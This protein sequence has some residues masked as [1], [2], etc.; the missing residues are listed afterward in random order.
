MKTTNVTEKAFVGNPH[1]RLDEGEVASAM[2]RRGSLLYVMRLVAFGVSVAAAWTA[3]ACQGTVLSVVQDVDGYNSWPMIQVV[4]G[5]LVCAY[6]RGKGHYVEGS[7]G[8]YA[9]TSSDGGRTWSPEVC[10]MNDPVICEGA[11]GAGRDSSGAAL[12]WMN[13]RGRG[14]IRHELYRTEDG[15]TFTKI[16]APE[17]SPEPIQVTGIFTVPDVGLMSL[18]FTGDYR[19]GEPCNSWGTLVSRDD[20]KT[21]EQRTMESGLAKQDWPTEICAVPLGGGRLLAIGRSEGNVQRQ[22]QLT[23]LDGG[24]T[25]RKS[26]TNI[27]DVKEST[28]SLIYDGETG[29]VSHYYY[30]RGPG[31]LWRRTAKVS[32]IFDRPEEW[33]SPVRVARGGKKRPYDSGNVTSVAMGDSHY[34]AYYSGDPTNTAVLVA[35]VPARPGSAPKR[36]NEQVTALILPSGK[37]VSRNMIEGVVG[38][39]DSPVVD[40][41]GKAVAAFEGGAR[42]IRSNDP[43]RLWR[44]IVPLVDAMNGEQTCGKGTGGD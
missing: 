36:E 31:I 34:L 24:V 37:L 16:A 2:P 26:R 3:C 40:D 30:Q 9:R 11:E 17:M 25:W 13:C 41:A 21:W 15:V 29:V 5:R 18:W 7:R 19:S 1:A 32:D 10:I 12:F 8:A 42:R 43:V 35:R 20:G 39:G 6:G 33:P 14:H 23:S 28:P 4:E 44:E 38:G 22:F 27:R